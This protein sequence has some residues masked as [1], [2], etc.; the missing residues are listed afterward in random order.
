[1]IYQITYVKDGNG[2]SK[3]VARPVK[4]RA[5]LMALRDSKEN[6]EQLAKARQGDSDAKARLLQLAYNIGH[7]DGQLAG[8]ESQGSFFFHDVDCYDA[9]QSA[10]IRDLIL[11][12]KEEIGLRLLE[13]SAGGGWHLV[14]R[15][16]K[17]QT[18]LENQ[19]RVAL[20]LKLEMDTNTHDLQRVVFST[21]GEAEDLVYLDD[22]I[23]TEPMSEEECQAE[24]KRLKEREKRGEEQVPAGA[25]KSNKHYRPWEE[26]IVSPAPKTSEAT[27]LAKS[28]LTV[29][30]ETAY[31]HPVVDYIYALLPDGAPVG[32]R[33]PWML[34]LAGDLLIMCDDDAEKVKEI[35]LS[36]QW[37]RDV[38]D[39][40]KR[41]MKELD[42]VIESAQKQKQKRESDN[43]YELLPS[44][45]MRRA[46]EKV[47]KRK[48]KMLVLEAHQKAMGNMDPTQRDDITQMLER[49][50]M[51][52]KKL[53]PYYPLLRLLCHG[54]KSKHYVAAMFVGGAF[55]MTLM[56]RCWYKFW[57]EPGRKCRLNCILELIGR[58]GSGKHIA[59]DLYKILMEPVKKADDAQVTALNKWNEE[60]DQNSGANKNK[61]P[62][63]QGV[64]RC[65]PSETSAAAIREAEFNAYETIDGEVWPLH[66]FQFN[67]ELDDMIRQSK[68]GYMDIETLFLK[69]FHNEPHGTFLKTTSSRIGEYDVHFNVVYT[70]TS[71]ALNRQA[72]E[73]SYLS[74]KLFRTTAVPMGDTNYEMR[75]NREYT[76]EDE[77][78]DQQ[79]L[80]WAR[81]FD[82]TKGE[83][84]CKPISDA[85]HDWTGRRMA[86]AAEEDSKAMEDLVKRPCWHAIN[87]ALPFIIS[88]HWDQMVKDE[89][90]RMKC[91][92]GFATDKYD[93]RLAIL[94]ANT[95]L[96]FQQHFFLGIG[97][98]YYDKE[99]IS[100]TS[101]SHL[102]QRSVSVLRQLPDPFT[103]EDV[104]KAFGYNGVKSSIS[105]RVKRL[106][107]DG[108]IQKIRTGEDKGKYRKL[109]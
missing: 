84:P 86:D 21:S 98:D 27:E 35:L 63:P 105:S 23:F 17:C 15:R 85:L 88:R 90:G 67:S 11:S 19:V 99:I 78:R 77:L 26:V 55:C 36:L 2:R 89:D 103:R 54:R 37:V 59:V 3:K 74:G 62:R 64:F 44:R 18:V 43:L 82:L 95:H 7:V 101:K 33:H 41:G 53:F 48:F 47:T 8:C 16:E 52:L 92:P 9:E 5:E 109:V 24:W 6:L 75:E 38:V 1:M 57:A 83:I 30:K 94:I 32:G 46:I 61:T 106:Q 29:S 39:D 14:C 49:I 108:L 97:E 28:V 102:Q 58:S 12:K 107:D 60:K 81:N 42:N 69:G 87:Y 100:S 65:M 68:K 4:D 66:V 71:D 13:R 80:A 20:A 96:A 93:K 56:T 31:G 73:A 76:E 22:E 45:E 51:E 50:G 79:L 104:D 10:A 91:G 72:S 70:G 40:P 25:K 34:K